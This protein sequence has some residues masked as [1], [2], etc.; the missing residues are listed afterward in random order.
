MYGLAAV[1]FSSAVGYSGPPSNASALTE[2]TRNVEFYSIAHMSALLPPGS[3]RVE[4]IGPGDHSLACG[5]YCA[6]TGCRWT[7]QY[8]CP[9]APPG[10]SGHASNDGSVGYACCCIDRSRES[11]PCGGNSTAGTPLQFTA[12][13]K[14]SP[15]QVV[16]MVV[17][18]TQD[19][20]MMSVAVDDKL[21]FNYTVPPGA[22]SL[23][24]DA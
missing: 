4:S 17:N 13:V 24:W 11:Q 2:I 9:W 8:S 16:L 20:Q 6:S 19:N 7:Q 1:S 18:P 23:V 3:Q 12:F 21:G 22:V 10:T 5:D 15:A 14:P